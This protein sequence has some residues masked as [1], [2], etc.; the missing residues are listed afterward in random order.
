MKYLKRCLKASCFWLR[1]KTM[2]VFIY[3][4]NWTHHESSINIKQS[5]NFPAQGSF[6]FQ[7]CSH[8][9]ELGPRPISLLQMMWLPTPGK[10]LG[11]VF[12]FPSHSNWWQNPWQSWK[13]WFPDEDT[14]AVRLCYTLVELLQLNGKRILNYHLAADWKRLYLFSE[15]L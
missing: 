15:M 14:N 3:T 13:Q 4:E 6:L 12:F 2:D 5:I 11:V 7:T 8:G 9:R 10:V 1:K